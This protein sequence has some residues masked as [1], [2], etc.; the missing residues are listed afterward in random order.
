MNISIYVKTLTHQK[1]KKDKPPKVKELKW[2]AIQ[3]YMQMI[4]TQKHIQNDSSL[5]KYK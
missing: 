2:S 3:R 4:N 1:K 5:G